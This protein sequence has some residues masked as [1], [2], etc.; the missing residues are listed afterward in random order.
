MK[1][2]LVLLSA[3]VLGAQV[4]G[5]PVVKRVLAQDQWGTNLLLDDS[6]HPW[7]EGFERE[8]GHFV[9]A[10]GTDDQIERGVSQTVELLQAHPI[11]IRAVA[12]SRAEGVGGS[13]D[14]DYSLYL[15]LIYMDGT[16][17]WGQIDPFATGTHDW[18]Q[19]EVIVLPEK[20]VRS[21]SFHMLL[22][23]HTGT[24]RFQAPVLHQ[25]VTPDDAVLFDGLPVQLS[26]PLTE[27]MQIRDVKEGSD[28]VLP[29]DG[30]ALGLEVRLNESPRNGAVLKD[31]HVADV[32]GKDRAITLFYTVPLSGESCTWFADPRNSEAATAD[33]EYMAAGGFRAG[34]NGRLSRYPF[35]AIQCGDRGIGIGI[36]MAAPAFF[37]VGLNMGT[38]E[39]FLAYDLGLTPEKHEARVRF[40]T[41]EFDPEWGFRAA[42]QKYVELFP[43]AFLCRVPEQGLWMPFARVSRVEGWEDFGFAFKEGS[44]EVSWD[45]AHNIA[46][47]RYTEPMTWWMPLEKGVPRT[48]EQALLTA[49][50]L[51]K[52]PDLPNSK[53]PQALLTS[54]YRDAQG[55]YVAQ[56]RNTPWCDGAVWSTNSMPAIRG[57]YTDFNLKWNAGLKQ[58]LYGADAEGVLDGEYIDSSEGYVTDELDLCRD[59]FAAADTPLTFSL[60]GRRPAI[61]RG[62][63]ARAT[64]EPWE[65][66]PWP[67][68]RHPGCA[69]WP[70]CSM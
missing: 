31:I 33:R 27:G 44:N 9:C 17:L 58:E 29:I 28:I 49:T 40:C 66:S 61:F 60:A 54:G 30:K 47:F 46:T 42:L 10:N 37:R 18:Q 20:P 55:Q 34:A 8:G 36:D 26:R 7:G 52:E 24:A 48:L 69:G 35:A 12:H 13:R 5:D 25:L 32:T 2:L 45:D 57:E 50:A 41:F 56:L 3:A 22:R 43:E 16:P 70:P 6:W 53:R 64:C 59:H 1:T 68:A 14:V 23:R 62:L 67:T 21:V 63:I 15:D 51:A 65:S 39:L 38:R 4:H 11:P 19:R